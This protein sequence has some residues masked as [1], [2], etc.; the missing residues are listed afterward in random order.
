MTL[1]QQELS[2]EK[3]RTLELLHKKEAGEEEKGDSPGDEAQSA[4]PEPGED[5]G[6]PPENISQ[7]TANLCLIEEQMKSLQKEKEQAETR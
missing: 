4:S 5:A 6:E 2:L 1:C 3:Q 7:L